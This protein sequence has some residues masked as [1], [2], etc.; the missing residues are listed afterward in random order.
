MAA[1]SPPAPTEGGEPIKPKT[2]VR[3]SPRVADQV[4]PYTYIGRRAIGEDLRQSGSMS[5][6]ELELAARIGDLR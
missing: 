5:Y 4:T 1:N 3:S 6:Q 2:E